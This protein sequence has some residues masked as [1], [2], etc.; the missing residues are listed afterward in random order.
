MPS[1]F[2]PWTPRFWQQLVNLPLSG[3]V[4]QTISP[5][6]FPTTI[7][8]TGLGEPALE[9]RIISEVAT[10][11]KQLGELTEVVLALAE[12][13]ELKHCD[14][15]QELQQ[16][17]TRIDDKKKE[18]ESLVHKRAQLALQKLAES[19][20]DEFSRLIATYSQGLNTERPVLRP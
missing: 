6:W 18:H 10:Y 4:D 20:P 14:A 17:V 11:G 12:S 1:R 9:Q 19:D 15:L 5:N 8:V 13:V 3:A 16:I 2:K 7:T